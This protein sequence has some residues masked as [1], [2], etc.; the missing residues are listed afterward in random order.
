MI[1]TP[2]GE[3]PIKDEALRDLILLGYRGS[4]AHGMHIG[5]HD[6][7]S[8]DDVDLM[9]VVVPNQDYY[10]GLR[11]YG[12][13]GTKEVK[14]GHWDIVK[15]EARKMVGLL[16]AANPN[17][18]ALL[19]LRDQDYLMRSTAGDLLIANRDLFLTKRCFN[20]FVGYAN[21]Q[22]QRMRRF[23]HAGYMGKKRKELVERY[24]YDTKCA[25]HLIRLLRMGCE[26]LTYGRLNVFRYND[27]EE[28]LDIKR[29]Q[30]T[31]EQVQEYSGELFR[32][33]RQARDQSNLPEQPDLDRINQLCCE[34]V[35]YGWNDPD[36]HLQK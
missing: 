25:S 11:E 4:V 19:W 9:G 3:V 33:I 29:G 8:I 17:V 34:V 1:Q 27:V 5:S 12:S 15:Y 16:A 28:L 26:A 18:L 24:G 23:E 30:W 2:Y 32:T 36:K 10:L 6:P 31:L 20:S 14:Q 21:S 7:D 13:R 22:L 35:Q